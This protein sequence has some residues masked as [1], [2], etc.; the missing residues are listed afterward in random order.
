MSRNNIVYWVTVF[1]IALI[2]A[3]LVYVRSGYMASSDQLKKQGLAAVQ[4][5]SVIFYGVFMPLVTGFFALKT[6]HSFLA[7]YGSGA[8]WNYLLLAASMA[9][10]FTVLAALVFKGR[11]F[12]EFTVLHIVYA[13]GFGWIMPLFFS[14]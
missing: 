8:N 7:K 13:A 6:Y 1:T 2:S 5:E 10:G 3:I 12:V 9:I 4:R 14:R 11:G